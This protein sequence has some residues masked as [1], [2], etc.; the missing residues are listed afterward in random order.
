MPAAPEG[1]RARTTRDRHAAVRAAAARGLTT[2]Q[3]SRE[4]HVDRKT[5]RRYTSAADPGGLILDAPVRRAGL[6][7][8]HLAYLHQRWEEG[9]HSTDQ[10]HAEL[11]A[12]GYAS[13]LRTLRRHTAALR[14]DTVT[15]ARPAAPASK[16]VA[17]WI[18]TAPGKLTAEQ[19]T[20]LDAITR[21]CPELA[22]TST[23]VRQ[24]A[25][26]LTHRQSSKLPGWAD[27]A[28]ASDVQ[29]I[30]SFAAGLR[31]DWPAVSAGLTLKW[32]SGTVEGHV[33]RIIMWNQICQ[34]EVRQAC[35]T[36][37]IGRLVA[38]VGGSSCRGVG[39][40]GVG[41]SASRSS[42]RLR[43]ASPSSTAA[44]SSSVSGIITRIFCRFALAS[45]SWAL[46]ES[47]GV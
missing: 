28:E 39:P 38:L 46:L 42:S 4:L 43:A 32:N 44:C 14:Q 17:A 25:D 5:V 19:H 10:L 11:R 40:A 47:F 13:S 30:R 6:L 33:N 9:C 20:A 31:M 34:V 29:E 36:S 45:R 7:D 41:V 12:R 27:R 22:A 1:Q 35:R 24:F 21:R 15:P 26:M 16:K 23:L 37:M 2:T 8:P 18:L 3:I